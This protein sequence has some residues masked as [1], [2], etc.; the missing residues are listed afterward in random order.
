METIETCERT[1][2]EDAEVGGG[3]GGCANEYREL[4][5]SARP[6]QDSTETKRIR[7]AMATVTQYFSYEYVDYLMHYLYSYTTIEIHLPT[8]EKYSL[9][10]VILFYTINF[11]L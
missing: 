1:R 8:V 7:P 6:H 5:Y 3:G 2:S 11:Q 4:P 9:I 10:I